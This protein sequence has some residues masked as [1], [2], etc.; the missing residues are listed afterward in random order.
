MLPGLKKIG[1]ISKEELIKII[2]GLAVIKDKIDKN[3]F[4][5]SRI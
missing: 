5:K 3:K 1:I 4:D 2:N